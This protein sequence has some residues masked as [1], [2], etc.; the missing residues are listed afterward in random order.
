MRQEHSLNLDTYRA[1]LTFFDNYA[2]VV[3][4]SP[5]LKEDV[6]IFRSQMEAI[7]AIVEED[8]SVTTVTFADKHELKAKICKNIRLALD[9]LNAHAIKMKDETL[10]TACKA[11]A[12]TFTNASDAD[13]IVK[14]RQE[15]T[16]MASFADVLDKYN[17]TADFRKEMAEDVETFNK[18]K[19]QLKVE[20]SKST[21]KTGNRNEL[22]KVMKEYV[23][24]VLFEAI[25]T[26]KDTQ[27]DFVK[28][29]ADVS[30]G[31]TPTVSSTKLLIKTIDE[32]TNQP[33]PNVAIEIPELK[34]KG[35]TDSNGKL[36]IKVG[37]KKEVKL[38]ATKAA[39]ENQEVS[40]TKI[41]RGRIKEIEV[42]MQGSAMTLMT[43]N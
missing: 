11:P 38:K 27:V 25:D 34:I 37:A 35:A 39:M 14:A 23:E 8:P 31:R 16:R 5:L 28:E 36:T 40:V 20:R 29:Y 7:E 24:G 19:P 42:R 43:V 26:L 4:N 12:S 18:M 15:V 32:L 2:D 6:G 22:F 30:T 13:F 3:E 10:K 9:K 17:L 33:I 41:L 1:M 21:V